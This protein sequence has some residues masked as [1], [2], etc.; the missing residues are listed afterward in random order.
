MLLKTADIQGLIFFAV[1]SLYF[2]TVC[3]L[4]PH[5][6]STGI[7][8]GIACLPVGVASLVGTPIA[9]ALIGRDNRWWHGIAFAGIAEMV[10]AALLA[11][12]WVVEKKRKMQKRS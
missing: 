2:P 7:R 4:D 12:A 3:A 8:L 9:E 11:F 5:V 1:V 6:G 10:S